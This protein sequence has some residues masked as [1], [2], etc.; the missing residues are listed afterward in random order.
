MATKKVKVEADVSPSLHKKFKA[1]AKKLKTSMADLIR[2]WM[3]VF[4]KS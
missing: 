3:Q 2:D 1:K 4:V